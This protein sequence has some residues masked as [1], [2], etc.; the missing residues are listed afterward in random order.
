MMVAETEGEEFNKYF[1]PQV[2]DA[3]PD[4][5]RPPQ[6][7]PDRALPTHVHIHVQPPAPHPLAPTPT[8]RL[9]FACTFAYNRHLLVPLARPLA[10]PCPRASCIFTYNHHLLDPFLDL[11]WSPP[12]HTRAEDWQTLEY[13]LVG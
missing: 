4:A 12:L 5:P 11:S 7:D 8:V 9:L 6:A 10:R 3:D 1:A 13:R 2:P